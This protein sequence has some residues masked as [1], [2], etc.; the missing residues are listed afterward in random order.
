MTLCFNDGT[1]FADA[2]VQAWITGADQAATTDSPVQ[3]YAGLR[4]EL[5]NQLN[6][7]GVEVVLLRLQA[8]HA[9]QGAPRHRSYAT[10]IAADLLGSRGLSWLA[11]DLYAN[12]ARL[13]RGTTAQLWEPELYQKVAQHSSDN[14]LTRTT[15]E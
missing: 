15:L 10:V 1:P 14:Q 2:Q 8:L 13:M 11:D 9:A 6:T 7:E 3:E 4:D 12:V 5:L